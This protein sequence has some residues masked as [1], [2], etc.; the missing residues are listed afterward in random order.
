MWKLIA[1]ALCSTAGFYCQTDPAITVCEEIVRSNLKAPKSYERVTANIVGRHVELAY[2]A[3]NSYNAPIRGHERCN[4]IVADGKW[5]FST[6]GAPVEKAKPFDA[7]TLS[8]KSVRELEEMQRQA[9]V[10][11]ETAAANLLKSIKAL[12]VA[13]ATGLIPIKAADTSLTDSG[14]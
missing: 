11:L 4:Y 7:S 3:V 2:D 14:S 10:E 12:G 1:A 13:K 6:L 9:K 8:G 5:S